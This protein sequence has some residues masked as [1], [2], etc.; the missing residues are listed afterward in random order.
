VEKAGH[1][2]SAKEKGLQA[3]R[4]RALK[5]IIEGPNAKGLYA[6]PT[7]LLIEQQQ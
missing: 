2:P 1:K 4:E 5:K 7:A 3:A 6:D